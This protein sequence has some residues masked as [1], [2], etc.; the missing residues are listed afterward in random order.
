LQGTT[1]AIP[2]LLVGGLV[3]NNKKSGS[4]AEFWIEAPSR[5]LPGE[6][7]ARRRRVVHAAAL[8]ELFRRAH[9]REASTADELR[10][11][12]AANESSD[13]INPA[14]ILTPEQIASALHD[15]L[16]RG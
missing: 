2:S 15:C 9:G 8:M 11:W 4:D 13:A 14:A 5:D 6:E 12:A 3:K 7:E 10:Q 16:R 1:P